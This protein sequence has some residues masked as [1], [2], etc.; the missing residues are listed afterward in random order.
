MSMEKCK[1]CNDESGEDGMMIVNTETG[2][3]VVEQ[4]MVDGNDRSDV[5]NQNWLISLFLRHKL[6]TECRH[7]TCKKLLLKNH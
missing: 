2:D 5:E 6:M 3:I 7:Y 1:Y 4:S